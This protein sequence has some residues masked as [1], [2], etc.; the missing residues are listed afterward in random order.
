M[1]LDSGIVSFQGQ[2]FQQ[3]HK[4]KAATLIKKPII[5]KQ[6]IY[7]RLGLTAS[8]LMLLCKLLVDGRVTCAVPLQLAR[9]GVR[10]FG[11]MRLR[12]RYYFITKHT[13]RLYSYYIVVT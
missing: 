13:V 4:K 1:V 8:K 11:H 5:Y 2:W 9:A 3:T 7:F 10:P 12:D 6:N